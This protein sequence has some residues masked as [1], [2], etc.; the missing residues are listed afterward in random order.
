MANLFSCLGRRIAKF[1]GGS[2]I[3]FGLLR[4]GCGLGDN[5]SQA[6]AALASMITSVSGEV[7]TLS[8]LDLHYAYKSESDFE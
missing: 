2:R 4:F 5:W 6:G 7:D 3:G 1:G 8:G